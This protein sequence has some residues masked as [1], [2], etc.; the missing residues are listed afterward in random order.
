MNELYVRVRVLLIFEFVNEG[1]L[2]DQFSVV[3][4]LRNIGH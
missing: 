1:V 2:V 3:L 4:F